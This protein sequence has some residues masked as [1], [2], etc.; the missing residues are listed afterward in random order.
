MLDVR[1][2]KW[3]Y[4]KGAA[5]AGAYGIKANKADYD[6]KA[7]YCLRCG[8]NGHPLCDCKAKWCI[9]GVILADAPGHGV[10]DAAHD[11][12]RK[13]FVPKKWDKKGKQAGDRDLS[14]SNPKQQQQSQQSNSEKKLDGQLRENDKIS[15]KMAAML[16]TGKALVARNKMLTALIN[17]S[18]DVSLIKATSMVPYVPPSS[19]TRSSRKRKNRG[20]NRDDDGDDESQ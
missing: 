8:R 4:V 11:V 5:P 9:C 2:F 20:G 17:K 19:S 7:P 1:A 16:A 15:A 12:A 14:R 10:R 13:N 18:E 6:A 3:D